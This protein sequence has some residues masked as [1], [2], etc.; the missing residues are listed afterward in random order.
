MEAAEL[1]EAQESLIAGSLAG[2]DEGLLLRGLYERLCA[3]GIPLLRVTVG[4]EEL[5]PLV[6]GRSVVWVRGD[7]ETVMKPYERAVLAVREEEWRRSPFYRLHLDKATRLRRRLG[8]NY[9]QGE[10]LFVDELFA[11]GGAD[12]VAYRLPY[13][14]GM[15]SSD[16]DCLFASWAA[17]GA[18]GFSDAD[19]AVID[20]LMPVLSLVLRSQSVVRSAENLMTTYLG[21]DAG[22]RV[23]CGQIERGRTERLNAAIWFSDL[24]GFTRIADTEP[25]QIV[26][27]LNDYADCQVAAIHAQGGQ[28][29]KFIG[30]GILAI[31]PIDDPAAACRRALD[32]A[33]AAF[34]ALPAINVRRAQSKLPVTRFYV[35]LHMGEVVYGNIGSSD[36]LDFTVVGPAVNE[37]NRIAALCRSVERDMVMSAGFAAAAR[38]TEPRLVSLG[39][40]ALRGVAKAQEVFTLDAPS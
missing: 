37:A 34:A 38:P 9:R 5:H 25:D 30:D 11:K 4:M 19:L 17:D 32:A 14:A 6:E 20:R 15:Q 39:R 33:D 31:F 29:L 12:Y 8:D 10:F 3:S 22:K 36:R 1:L 7:A 24:A 27:L 21:R 35:G 23:L 16:T 28:V 26:P 18:K 13:A 2:V 40:Y